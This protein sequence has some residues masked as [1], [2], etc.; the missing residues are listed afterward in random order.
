MKRRF[1][2]DSFARPVDWLVIKSRYNGYCRMC[3]KQFK[4]GTRIYFNIKSKRVQ[5]LDCMPDQ[6]KVEH[7]DIPVVVEPKIPE[8]IRNSPTTKNPRGRQVQSW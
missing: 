3:S 5:C 8:Y 7:P 2:V 6:Q 4:T 1:E